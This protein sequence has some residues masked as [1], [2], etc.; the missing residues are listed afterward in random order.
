MGERPFGHESS[1]I[2]VRRVV[3]IAAVI[4]ACVIAVV[5]MIDISLKRWIFPGREEVVARRAAIPP[6]PRLQPNPAVDIESL[7]EE[8][9]ALLSTWQ[10][11][12]RTQTFA[13]IPIERAMA[14][15]VTQH[16]DVTDTAVGSTPP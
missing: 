4:A 16:S 3:G 15:Y 10:W 14:L 6:P 9:E 8:K 5:L 1:G 13:R 2:A 7:R 12:D 11:T